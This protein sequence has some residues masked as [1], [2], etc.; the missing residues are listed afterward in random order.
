MISRILTKRALF[1][2]VAKPQ[3]RSFTNFTRL[4]AV[5]TPLFYGAQFRQF[6]EGAAPAKNCVF[7]PSIGSLLESEVQE[8]FNEKNATRVNFFSPGNQPGLTRAWIYFPTDEAAA[9]FL[10]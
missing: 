3:V 5:R 1:A 9:A 4:A 7:I 10:E 2:A 8:Y 6:S